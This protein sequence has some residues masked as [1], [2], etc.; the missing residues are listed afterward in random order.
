MTERDDIPTSIVVCS[1]VTSAYPF[2]VCV[3]ACV[4]VCGGEGG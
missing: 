1:Y 4:H 2:G 3:S